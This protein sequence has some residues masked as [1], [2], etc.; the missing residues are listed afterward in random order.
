MVFQPTCPGPR[1]ARVKIVMNK[2]GSFRKVYGETH[3]IQW[4]VKSMVF[5]RDAVA[6][7]GRDIE[8]TYEN[9]RVR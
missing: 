5:Q 1:T 7:Y 9:A 8:I 2:R 3:G 6:T 4:F